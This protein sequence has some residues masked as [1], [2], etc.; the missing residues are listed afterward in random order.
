MIPQ[1]QLPYAVIFTALEVV[2]FEDTLLLNRY[3]CYV[4]IAFLLCV[5]HA[6]KTLQLVLNCLKVHTLKALTPAA[7]SFGTI[8]NVEWE[9]NCLCNATENHWLPFHVKVA[10]W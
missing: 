10:L 1:T 9:G 6:L 2:F 4:K 7:I 8:K 5:V 3:K